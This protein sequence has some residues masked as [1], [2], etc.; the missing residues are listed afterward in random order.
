MA[1]AWLYRTWKAIAVTLVIMSI[2]YL[3][4]L[5]LAGG[6]VGGNYNWMIFPAAHWGV[7]EH[8]YT[9]EVTPLFMDDK[10][11]GWDGQFYYY[12]SNDLLGSEATARHIDSPSYRYQRIGI[13]FLA[14]L[15]SHLLGSDYVT[16]AAFFFTQ[17]LLAGMATYAILSYLRRNGRSMLWCLPWVF[18]LGT[19]LT[20][21]HCLVD[22]GADA[23][24]LL[25]GICFLRRRLV[26]YAL[27]M[28]L[29]CL[30]REGFASFAA[31]IFVL[32]LW[33]WRQAILSHKK[34]LLLLALPGCAIAAWI[35]YVSV[36][37]GKMPASQATGI[38]GLPFVAT[39][40]AFI[41][42]E[43]SFHWNE[44]IGLMVYVTTVLFSLYIFYLSGKKEKFFW[45]GI[46]YTFLLACFG[47]TVMGDI[48]G[49][50]KGI[51]V[52]F[53]LI[54]LAL[55]SFPAAHL[56]GD[57][58]RLIPYFAAGLLFLELFIS[59][60]GYS[61]RFEWAY[62]NAIGA[63]E[64]HLVDARASQP[65]HL[66][67]SVEVV[68]S[69]P[70]HFPMLPLQRYVAFHPSKTLKVAI[71]NHSDD[72]WYCHSNQEGKYGVYLQG[73]WTDGDR[74]IK[75]DPLYHIDGD[76]APGETVITEMQVASPSKDGTFAY[77]LS[78]VQKNSDEVKEM[79]VESISFSRKE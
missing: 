53:A 70:N 4:I 54:P 74:V 6:S 3:N 77:H 38:L 48:T 50:F 40:E 32:G 71:T 28:T 1:K 30:S 79:T 64:Q 31:A 75:V 17:L 27:F 36:H 58:Q 63:K 14:S 46:P 55:I 2:V 59:V 20:L 5:R 56:T 41:R 33:K 24:F 11:L 43:R 76:I 18:T 35:F 7:P 68:S 47:L 15:F 9:H 73:R 26:G 12:M 66:V 61:S 51:S 60:Q 23:L 13:P 29:A 65:V 57:R 45:A 62:P 19:Q 72:V 37:F 21:F 67:G 16:V 49:Y 25:A 34:E 52:L 8:A 10:E 22:A 44:S 42:A 78:L 39:V 69:E